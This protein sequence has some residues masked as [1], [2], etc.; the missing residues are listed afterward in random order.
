MFKT[1]LLLS[2]GE[3]FVLLIEALPYYVN[4]NI[5]QPLKQIR[6]FT[7]ICHFRC[8]R[9]KG[10]FLVPYRFFSHFLTVGL[11]QMER[12]FQRNNVNRKMMYCWNSLLQLFAEACTSC[13]KMYVSSP[14][15]LGLEV[16]YI[17]L[18]QKKIEP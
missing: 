9:A 16:Y 5:K 13:T 12:F 3:L 1:E 14:K 4:Y 18:K 10:R 7:L 15:S 17:D 6:A 8:S 11:S 2:F